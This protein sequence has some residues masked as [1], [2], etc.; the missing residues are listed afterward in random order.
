MKKLILIFVLI[1]LLG[2]IY[3]QDII[4]QKIRRFSVEI[5]ISQN[6]PFSN[7]YNIEVGDKNKPFWFYQSY[8]V[9]ASTMLGLNVSIGYE[10]SICKKFYL[11]P[12]ISYF[13]N[14]QKKIS[15]GHWY[16]YE[17]YKFIGFVKS[18]YRIHSLAV[19]TSF[20]YK[21]NRVVIENG[22]GV[23][24]NF[25]QLFVYDYMDYP[26]G[27]ELHKKYSTYT[28]YDDDLMVYLFSYHKVSY[29]LVK[30]RLDLNLGAYINYSKVKYVYYYQPFTQ[31]INPTLSLKLKL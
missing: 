10:I 25:F 19:S 17:G 6:I 11:I 12:N 26:S 13:L 27:A 1:S 18:K 28:K 24:N 7:N 8:Y 16:S 9:Y 2:R 22:I 20:G 21:I 29:E 5:G 3:A 23:L 14:N 15:V 31:S 30:N 4:K